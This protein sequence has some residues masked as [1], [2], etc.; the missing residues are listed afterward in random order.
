MLS[1]SVLAARIDGKKVTTM[2][3]FRKKQKNLE[4]FLP[5][6]TRNSARFCNQVYHRMRHD[7]ELTDL[8]RMRSGYLAGN[9]AAAPALLDRPEVS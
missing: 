4:L 2:E 8:Q 9:L 5:M 1:C 6:I 7:K 3:V